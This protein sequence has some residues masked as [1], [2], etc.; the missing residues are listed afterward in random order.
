MTLLSDYSS[1]NGPD[2]I[3]G[4]H[5]STFSLEDHQWWNLHLPG[6]IHMTLHLTKFRI[7]CK[8]NSALALLS[9]VLEAR[10]QRNL[11]LPPAGYVPH[12]DML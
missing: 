10:R 7:Y 11:G 12:S 2:S 8:A 1:S 5:G 4:S 9:E 3:Y 6:S